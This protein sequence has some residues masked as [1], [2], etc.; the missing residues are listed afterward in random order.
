[1]LSLYTVLPYICI[2][3]YVCAVQ[4]I[5]YLFA[6][7]QSVQ[8]WVCVRSH[9]VCALAFGRRPILWRLARPWTGPGCSFCSV[10]LFCF[11]LFCFCCWLLASTLLGR[12]HGRTDG[13]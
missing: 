7:A 3:I 11:F 1:M 8:V 6:Q 9:Y 5:F 2:Y 4:F 12:G 13:P 10:F